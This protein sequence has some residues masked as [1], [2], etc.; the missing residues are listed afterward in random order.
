[1]KK[2]NRPYEEYLDYQQKRLYNNGVLKDMGIRE[3]LEYVLGY[4]KEQSRKIPIFYLPD[5]DD[6][7]D[8]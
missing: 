5:D 8:K 7:N 1:M 3:R 2:T 4:S 6:I